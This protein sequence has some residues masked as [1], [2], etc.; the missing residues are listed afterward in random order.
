[1]GLKLIKTVKNG[2]LYNDEGGNPYIRIDNVRLSYAFLG[3]PSQDESDKIDP[4]T[5]QKTIV[6]RWRTNGLMKKDTH[7]EVKNLCV[8]VIRSLMTKNGDEKGPAKVPKDKWFITDGDEKEGEHEQGCWVISAADP[9]VRPTARNEAGV[10]IV[11]SKEAD[12]KKID[13]MLYS[14]CWAN[15][16]VRPWYFGG[17]ARGDSKTY[18]KRISAGISTVQKVKNDTPFGA[19]RVDDSDIWGSVGGA[20]S[21]T[22]GGGDGLD[23]DDD[24][25]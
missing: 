8:E 14:G 24:V 17:K 4:A 16:L 12:L 5:G 20:T 21:Q 15:M 13:E 23:D 7:E 18:P 2:A 1:M 9:K 6:P 10:E 19:G 3:E 22:S 25:L 11:V